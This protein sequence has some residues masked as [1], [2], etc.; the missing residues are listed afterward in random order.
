MKKALDH[1][2]KDF[3]NKYYNRKPE[4]VDTIV[5][6]CRRGKRSLEA[7]DIAIKEG[8]TKSVLEMLIENT[9]SICC[10]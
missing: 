1:E 5:F 7:V 10:C 8:Y 6:M 2:P 4:E 3:E 9:C